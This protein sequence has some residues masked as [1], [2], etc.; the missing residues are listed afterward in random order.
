MVPGR[1]LLRAMAGR[2]HGGAAV[3]PNAKGIGA[4][5][6]AG[7]TADRRSEPPASPGARR[8]GRRSP[9]GMTIIAGGA[10]TERTL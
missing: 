4:A 7:F 3:Q 8:C 1:R 6:L 5:A 9:G 10:E 2:R